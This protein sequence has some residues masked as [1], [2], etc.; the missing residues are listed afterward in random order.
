MEL[1]AFVLISKQCRK[2][3]AR[4][5]VELAETP[6]VQEI[7]IIAGEYCYLVKVR[8]AGMEQ[9]HDIIN[10]RIPSIEGVDATQTIIVLKTVKEN[11]AAADRRS[12]GVSR[13][14]LVGRRGPSR[15]LL[16]GARQLEHS[17]HRVR[18]S[19]LDSAT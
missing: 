15:L 6:G 13:R 19:C 3:S 12:R 10:E 17:F 2:Q 4:P 1:L 18:P 8:A 16:V 14:R 5:E 11:S 9:L 7:H